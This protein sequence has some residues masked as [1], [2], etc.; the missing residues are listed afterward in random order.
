MYEPI[1]EV[2]SMRWNVHGDD[3]GHG[4]QFGTDTNANTSID[5]T[6]TESVTLFLEKM[7]MMEG[8]KTT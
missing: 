2:K 3:K 5:N 7:S 4:H 6:Y 8:L 1:E